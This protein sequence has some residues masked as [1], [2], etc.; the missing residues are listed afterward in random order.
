MTVWSAAESAQHGDGERGE[1]RGTYEQRAEQGKD[2]RPFR[3]DA[4]EPDPPP[5][6]RPRDDEDKEHPDSRALIPSRNTPPISERERE[7]QET[8][9]AES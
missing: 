4:R 2:V 3:A 6:S 9:T 1:G 8:P 5:R 7:K